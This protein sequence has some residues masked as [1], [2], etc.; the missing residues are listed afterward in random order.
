MRCKLAIGSLAILANG[1]RRT[2]CRTAVAILGFRMAGVTLTDS[3]VGLL[4]AVLRPLTPVMAE[5][6]AGFKGCFLGSSSGTQTAGSAGLVINR[7]FGARGSGL[8]ILGIH[9]FRCEL[10][11][12]QIAIFTA[13]VLANGLVRAGRRTAA[14]ILG[15]RMAC[16]SGAHA[17]V[18]AVAVGRPGAIVVA[19]DIAGEEGRLAC[20]ALG[21]QAA[22]SAGLVILC[23]FCAGGTSFQVLCLCLLCRKAVCLKNCL[24]GHIFGGHGKGIARDRDITAENIPFLE[25]I[26]LIGCG[27]QRD[28]LALRS[29]CRRSLCRTATFCRHR[30]IVFMSTCC[31]LQLLVVVILHVRIC[32]VVGKEK[33]L[34]VLP[35]GIGK[36]HGIVRVRSFDANGRAGRHGSANGQR[37][38]G[39][40]VHIV[41]LAGDSVAGHDRGTADVQ[42][43]VVVGVDINAAATAIGG[44]LF[45]LAVGQVADRAAAVD[46]HA[47]TVAGGRIAGNLA[48]RHVQFRRLLIQI[49]SAAVHAGV[50]GD[51]TAREVEG[52]VF[53]DYM[54]RAALLRSFVAADLAAPHVERRHLI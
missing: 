26:A 33:C 52:A 32:G 23:L 47:A 1:F 43:P 12:C 24:D 42:L 10:M 40:E 38:A 21:T 37:L 41:G 46:V 11:V 2:G 13:A 14:A 22:D 4:I 53:I 16:I 36:H 29:L 35:I 20:R 50:S 34:I 7:R 5:D 45:N 31:Q 48:A 3:G 39:G 25:M 27:G 9:G 49:D 18:G 54:N 30:N 51:L 17:G 28:G 19:Q 8:E 15:F 44:I 6:I